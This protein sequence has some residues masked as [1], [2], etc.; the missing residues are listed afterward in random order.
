M[1][2]GQASSILRPIEVPSSWPSSHS[3]KLEANSTYLVSL[4]VCSHVPALR[5]SFPAV[6]AFVW[7]LPS[8]P[9]NVDLEGA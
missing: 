2:I 1:I 5:E 7:L 6:F 9:P 3:F 8:M 4:E